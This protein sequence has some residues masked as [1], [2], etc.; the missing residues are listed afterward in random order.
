MLFTGYVLI[1]LPKMCDIFA[2]KQQLMP[3]PEQ[4]SSAM[5]DKSPADLERQ[6]EHLKRAV[7][8]LE[9]RNIVS[10]AIQENTH[11][12]KQEVSNEF[13]LNEYFEP[14]TL[15]GSHKQVYVPKERLVVNNIQDVG[16]EKDSDGASGKY[17]FK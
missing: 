2:G 17:R 3:I 11:P 15:P 5:S 16:N 1:H 8:A 9:S 4:N 6:T 10:P 12:N 13:I 14:K 7:G